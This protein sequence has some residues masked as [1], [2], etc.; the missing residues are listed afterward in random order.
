ML[1]AKNGDV[2]CIRA[3]AELKADLNT[4][5]KEGIAMQGHPRMFL[6]QAPY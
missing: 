5:N 4:R 3:L 1:A 6:I 2:E